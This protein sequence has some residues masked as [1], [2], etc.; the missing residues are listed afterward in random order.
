MPQASQ[1]PQPNVFHAVEGAAQSVGHL[2]QAQPLQMM[3]DQDLAVIVGA[4]PGCGPTAARIDP[5]RQPTGAPTAH[6]G[7]GCRNSDGSTWPAATPGPAAANP[8]IPP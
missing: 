3:Q 7:A 6:P 4:S 1:G 5:T 8:R 2:R